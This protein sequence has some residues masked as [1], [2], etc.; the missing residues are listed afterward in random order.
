MIHY[1]MSVTKESDNK[2][3]DYN[4]TILY[5]KGTNF[6]LKNEEEVY[7]LFLSVDVLLHNV[8][9]LSPKAPTCSL[10]GHPT[11]LGQNFNATA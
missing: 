7:N 2:I 9:I 8:N 10:Y 3:H 1:S 5:G 11:D 4:I 6:A